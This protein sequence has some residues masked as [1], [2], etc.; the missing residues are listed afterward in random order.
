MRHR[1]RQALLVAL[2]AYV[3]GQIA[4][5]GKKQNDIAREHAMMRKKIA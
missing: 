2:G 1:I 5:R 3:V 4:S